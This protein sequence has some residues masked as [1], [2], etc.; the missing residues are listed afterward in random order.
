MKRTIG[1]ARIAVAGMVLMGGAL[2]IFG[3]MKHATNTQAYPRIPRTEQEQ[4]ARVRTDGTGSP[5][6]DT[7]SLAA[8][9]RG[10]TDPC[11]PTAPITFSARVAVL[12]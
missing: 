7:L 8:R 9:S 5:I 6:A 12:C 4:A 1:T 3:D 10:E 2:G 11:I